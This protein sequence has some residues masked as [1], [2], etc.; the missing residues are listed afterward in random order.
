MSKDVAGC[1]VDLL[2]TKAENRKNRLQLRVDN[3]NKLSVLNDHERIDC[4]YHSLLLKPFATNVGEH[5]Q[6]YVVCE[7]L[8][9]YNNSDYSTYTVK[10]FCDTT[11]HVHIHKS[12]VFLADALKDMGFNFIEASGYVKFNPMNYKYK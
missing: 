3:N 7:G 4:L 1:V 9:N 2:E 12:E 10:S 5:F 6:L 11:C 8:C